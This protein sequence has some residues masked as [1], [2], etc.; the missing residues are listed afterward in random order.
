MVFTFALV[1]LGGWVATTLATYVASRRLADG[2]TTL[3]SALCYSLLAG[4]M[5]PFL[6]VGVVEFS[7]VAMYSTATS[8]R[9]HP[10]VPESWLRVGATDRVVVP[11]R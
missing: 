7:S 10:E 2:S 6:I 3:L 8:R 11:L 5:W 4:M 1:Y 9:D